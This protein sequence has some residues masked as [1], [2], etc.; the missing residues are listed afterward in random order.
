MSFK[1]NIFLSLGISDIKPCEYRLTLLGK[2][3]VYVEGVKRVLDISPCCVL[4]DVKCGKLLIKGQNLNIKSLN[5]GDI[6]ISGI[7]FSVEVKDNFI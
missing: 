6:S 5:G 1:D 7:I 4:I 3:G 2:T